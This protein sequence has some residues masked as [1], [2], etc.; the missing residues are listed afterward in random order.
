[1][2]SVHYC[3][4]I[5][6]TIKTSRQLNTGGIVFTIVAN[7]PH[8]YNPYAYPPDFSSEFSQSLKGVSFVSGL[9][10]I[11]RGSLKCVLG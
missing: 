1:M 9:T 5:S 7:M 4:L 8:T 11:V 2:V 3:T 10:E 6:Y